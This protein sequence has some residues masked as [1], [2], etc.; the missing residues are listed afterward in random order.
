MT[1]RPSNPATWFQ[2]LFPSEA[3]LNKAT[4]P[5]AELL[6]LTERIIRGDLSREALRLHLKPDG[7][8]HLR[9]N[10]NGRPGPR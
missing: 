3:A 10:P 9:G 8:T 7:M 4:K 1:E 2:L 5:D 6:T